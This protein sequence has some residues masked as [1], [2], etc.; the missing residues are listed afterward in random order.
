M[1][2]MCPPEYDVRPE[3]H[4]AHG[5]GN[6]V[7]DIVVRM[8]PYDLRTIIETEYGEPAVADAREKLGFRFGDSTIPMKSIL[9]VGIP[10]ELGEL[11]QASLDERLTSDEPQFKLQVV[12]GA[13]SDAATVSL[14]PPPPPIQA[15]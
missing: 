8:E 15:L 2:K 7:P 9:A 13:G 5:Q 3:Q 6:L 14:T 10:E 11:D 1:Q 12:T 4:G